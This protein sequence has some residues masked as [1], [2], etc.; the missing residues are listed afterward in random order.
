[1]VTLG[2]VTW[3]PPKQPNGVITAYEVIYYEYNANTPVQTKQLDP[4]ETMYMHTMSYLGK[5]DM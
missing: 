3:S 4:N 5:K 2:M 1:M